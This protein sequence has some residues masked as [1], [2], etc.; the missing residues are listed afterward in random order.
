M[1]ELTITLLGTPQI[2]VDG[3]PIQVDTRKAV[4][5]LAYLAMQPGAHG[6]DTLAALLWPELDG[7]RA[8]AALRRTLS[9]LN[10]T[11][12]A[13]WLAANREAIELVIDDR[14]V[15]DVATF[16][17]HMAA[18]AT[19]GHEPDQPCA[20]CIPSL[21][22]AAQLYRADFMAG[23]SL[24]DSAEFDDWQF[25]LA[26]DLR[27]ELT[28]A[29]DRLVDA[30]IQ[31]GR[32]DEAIAHARRRL[33]VD[34][35]HE[36]THRTLMQ[37][38]V[39]ANQRN[40]ALRQYRECVRILNDELGVAPLDATTELYAAIQRNAP[41]PRPAKA[42]S[43]TT[44]PA[45]ES[46]AHRASSTRAPSALPTV[47]TAYPL[48]GRG[49]EWQTLVDALDTPG[50]RLILI[51]GEAGIGK[52][53]LV[54]L[55]LHQ[56]AQT[57]RPVLATQCYDGETQLAYAPIIDLLRQ[58][59][60]AI[61]VDV[62]AQISASWLA[63]AQRLLPEIR[64]TMTGLPV[65]AQLDNAAA[66][67]RFFEAIS[68]LFSQALA[69]SASGLLVVDNVHWADQASRELLV[70]L[71]RRLDALG[72][73]VVLTWR[74]EGA[75]LD[76]SFHS[77][78]A[79][80][81]H[82]VETVELELARLPM[83]DVARLITAVLDGDEMPVDR[84]AQRLMTE[85]EGNPLFLIEYLEL[86]QQ[87]PEL[88]RQSA[89]SLP[90]GVRALLET[91]IEALGEA[92]RQELTAAAAIGRMFH[93][94][95]LQAASGRS[96]EET[97]SALEELLAHRLVREVDGLTYDF[98]H[99]QLRVFVYGEMSAARRRLLHRR[100]GDALRLHARR[101]GIDGLPHA[102]TLA[103]HLDA[104]GLPDQAVAAYLDAAAQARR[105]YANREAIGFLQ[106][107]LA[108]G[109]EDVAS[110]QLQL[111]NLYTLV[112]D[113]GAARAGYEAAAAHADP[114]RLAEIEF[115][116][117][118]L[119]QRLGDSDLA[120]GC[121]D[122]ALAS[123]PPEEGAR[124]SRIL[125][126]WSFAAER[127]GKRDHA[128]TLALAAQAAATA[129]ENAL[130]LAEAHNVLAI[131]ARHNDQCEE[132]I[133]QAE[134]SLEWAQKA[135]DS[136][137]IVAA[138]NSLALAHAAV[139]DHDTTAA[140]LHRAIE[141]CAEQGDRHRE[142]ALHNHLADCYHTVGRNTEAMA[143]LKHAVAL[144]AEIGEEHTLD[145]P[146]IWKLTEW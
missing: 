83:E 23:F 46:P 127:Q 114:S 21:T 100:I 81:R 53:R 136:T 96:E 124:R 106:R 109:A 119:H 11:P 130:A 117:G 116:L 54:E 78:L 129:A 13:P 111:G 74:T 80:I 5:M 63:E 48:V 118:M 36:P 18:C 45:S 41:M 43:P 72:I 113:Y 122:A 58:C 143:E 101:L 69:G 93:F 137:A 92:A 19:H 107:A 60:A 37:L 142:A 110:V 85:T 61:P 29:L 40:A 87:Q 95:L 49:A 64:Q 105:V 94:D 140:L 135:G 131:L 89:W 128:R 30:L 123:L 1:A 121:F 38:F 146:E 42:A 84:L 141:L 7:S 10:A 59:L 103:F 68:R 126:Q 26:E 120:G 56:A 31:G 98:Y 102:A 55:L 88:T 50:S 28:T 52:T 97:I 138:L 104:G 51:E 9:T 144:F 14:I 6:R 71:L 125:A 86:F 133:T 16:R 32:D 27:R 79:G 4:A 62:T 132:A 145:N 115:R 15:L 57:Q 47:P 82:S 33:Q 25:F 3:A 17:R 22:A 44:S 20:A 8:R 70:Y 134:M 39:W 76:T 75:A 112:G 12:F 24:R 139:D 90:A 35:L 34:P 2:T 99:D 91:R 73:I 66:K 77:A 67:S 108:L 65:L